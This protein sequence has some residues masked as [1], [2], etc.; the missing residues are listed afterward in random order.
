MPL[1]AMIQSSDSQNPSTPTLVVY[2]SLSDTWYELDA[3]LWID[4]AL[5][6]DDPDEEEPVYA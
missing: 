4:L 2:D 6:G 1:E 5:Q 3:D